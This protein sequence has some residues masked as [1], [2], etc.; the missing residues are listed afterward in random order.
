MVAKDPRSAEHLM[1]KHVY[2]LAAHAHL[3]M[4]NVFN[5]DYWNS[6]GGVLP[7][8]IIGTAGATRDNLPKDS[9]PA[10]AA[11]TRVYGYLLGTVSPPGGDDGPISFKYYKVKKSD[12]PNSTALKFRTG[13][14]KWCFQNNYRGGKALPA[15]H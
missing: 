6:H 4:A 11:M 1:H 5:T 2:V 14:V 8:W 15:Q 9:G 3:Y 10:S 12:V 13:L 7:G